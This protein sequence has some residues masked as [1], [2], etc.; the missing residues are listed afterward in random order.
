MGLYDRD[1]VRRQQSGFSLGGDRS[2]VTNLIL[3]NVG[4]FVL[5]IL[6]GGKLSRFLLLNVDVVQQPWNVW[7]LL[8]YGFVHDPNTIWHVAFNMF[9]LWLFGRDMEGVY[10]RKEFLRV[11]LAMIMFAGLAWLLVQYLATAAG[12][13]AGGRLLGASG[14]VVGV[15]VLYVLHYPHRIFYIWGI[16]PLP[17]WA[18][19][20]FVLVSDLLGFLG[21]WTSDGEPVAY[22][23]H[24]AGAAFA[25]IYYRAGWNLGRLLPGKGGWKL[26]LPR[27]P[28]LRIHQPRGEEPYSSPRREAE[29][30]ADDAQMQDRLDAILDKITREGKDSLSREEQRF[31]E[32]A[33]RRYQQRRQ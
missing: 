7:Q 15:M 21:I 12:H 4:I 31:L 32:D 18:F 9:G 23:A 5:D 6:A 17:V 8:T 28:R 20:V 13:P 14:G 30:R 24:L 19:C 16:L 29:P 26:K 2:M 22:E 10:G 27:G 11:Y 33:S 25:A 3:V 1:Y